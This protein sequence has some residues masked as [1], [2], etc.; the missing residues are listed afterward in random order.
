MAVIHCLTL[1][2]VMMRSVKGHSSHTDQLFH[3]QDEVYQWAN[4]LY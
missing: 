1:L 3:T 4:V 2:F